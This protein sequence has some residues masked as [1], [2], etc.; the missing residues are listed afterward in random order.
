MFATLVPNAVSPPSENTR[1]WSVT[2]SVIT[3][4]ALPRSQQ[5][6]QGGR[7]Q[8]VSARAESNREIQHLRGKYKCAG[9]RQQR[10]HVR[11]F[12]RFTRCVPGTDCQGTGRRDGSHDIHRPRHES[13]RNMHISQTAV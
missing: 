1:A 2:T 6:G 9:G 11:L 13:V 4:H 5:R 7:S 3:R 8:E 12:P 10:H